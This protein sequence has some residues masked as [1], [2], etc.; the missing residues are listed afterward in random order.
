MPNFILIV[1]GPCSIFSLIFSPLPPSLASHQ[2]NN[3]KRKKD[4]VKMD[5]EHLVAVTLIGAFL[6]IAFCFWGVYFFIYDS[7]TQQQSAAGNI[8]HVL[9]GVVVFG[10]ITSLACGA[11]LYKFCVRKNAQVHDNNSQV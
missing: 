8:G 9:L 6:G 3:T 2:P 4:R 5:D 7:S 11:A 10:A 1:E